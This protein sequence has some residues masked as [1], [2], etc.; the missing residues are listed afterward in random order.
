[1]EINWI[2]TIV[3]ILSGLAVCIPLVVKLYQL[4]KELVKNKNW[5]CLLSLVLEEMKKAQAEYERGSDRKK[6]I[7][8]ILIDLAQR[9]NYPIEEEDVSKIS[10][11]IDEMC[12]MAHV[13]GV[14]TN[15]ACEEVTGE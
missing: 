11:M 12:D 15:K 10:N 8:S 13:V 7:M 6:Y 1:M 5:N 2:N 3:S 14:K 9:A 4:I